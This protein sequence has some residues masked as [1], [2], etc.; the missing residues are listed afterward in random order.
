MRNH[1]VEQC[2]LATEYLDELVV[3]VN[4]GKIR[5]PVWGFIPE[6]AYNFPDVDWHI[7]VAVPQRSKLVGVAPSA[8]RDPEAAVSRKT[9]ALLLFDRLRSLG[10]VHLGHMVFVI[11]CLDAPSARRHR[12]IARN[13]KL[14]PPSLSLLPAGWNWKMVANFNQ[15]VLPLD[16][17]H[18]QPASSLRWKDV[19]L[20]DRWFR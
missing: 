13:D 7:S 12:A 18:S 9:P 14:V 11:N 4:L 19:R 6:A 8:Y 15:T 2:F 20:A 3:E 17:A 1:N 5:L 16:P 10:V